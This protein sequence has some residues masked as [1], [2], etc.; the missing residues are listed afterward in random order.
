MDDLPNKP[1]VWVLTKQ[2]IRSSTSIGANYRAAFRAKSDADFVYKLKIVEEETDETIYWLEVL[3]E[4][5]LVDNQKIQLLKQE[6]EEILSIVVATIK[7][8]RLNINNKQ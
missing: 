4:S 6:C 5:K 8:K 7:T 2:I 1:S 3:E